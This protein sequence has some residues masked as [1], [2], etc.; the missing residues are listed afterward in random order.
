MQL[1][2]ESVRV[3]AGVVVTA[4][5]IMRERREQ[6]EVARGSANSRRHIGRVRVS[7]KSTRR[8]AERRVSSRVEL[9]V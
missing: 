8:V 1:I 3:H 2:I 4:L 6:R 7:S 9:A 5:T